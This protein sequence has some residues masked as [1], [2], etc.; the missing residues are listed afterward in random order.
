MV[1]LPEVPRNAEGRKAKVAPRGEVPK[2]A[3]KDSIKAGVRKPRP[4]AASR[5]WTSEKLGKAKFAEFV[6]HALR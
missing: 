4:Y 5:M 6:F 3:A 2:G 1:A